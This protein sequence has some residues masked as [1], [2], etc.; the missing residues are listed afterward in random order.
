M[1]MLADTH[2]DSAVLISLRGT[3]QPYYA[4]DKF[5]F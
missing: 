2:L 3:D 5:V 1:T 4:S